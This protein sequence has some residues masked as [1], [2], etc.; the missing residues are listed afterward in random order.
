MLRE[1]LAGKLVSLA[2]TVTTGNSDFVGSIQGYL[3]TAHI[4]KG[5]DCFSEFEVIC[6]YQTNSGAAIVVNTTIDGVV[7]QGEGTNG[8]I[9]K[10]IASHKALMGMNVGLSSTVYCHFIL[11]F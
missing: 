3:V 2:G 11:A 8:Q 7:Y 6:T 5:P 4:L 9:A 1:I 10:T